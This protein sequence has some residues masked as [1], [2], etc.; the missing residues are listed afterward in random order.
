MGGP[1]SSK[2][3]GRKLQYTT[4]NNIKEC[5]VSHFLEH[6]NAMP[7][8][9]NPECFGLNQDADLAYQLKETTEM[10]NVLL[11]IRPKEG[12]GGEGKSVD[13]IVK[14]TVNDFLSKMPP[15]YDLKQV[16]DQVNRLG[17]PP[18]LIAHGKA[19]KGLD[20]PLN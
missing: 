4:P 12:G 11:E 19:A 16:R 10:L 7:D 1:K 17:G 13:E 9:D 18:K 20:V 14:D 15:V 8:N 5:D 6:I 2:A 3:P